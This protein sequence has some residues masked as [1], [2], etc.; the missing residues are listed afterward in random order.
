[1]S[2]SW[3]LLKGWSLRPVLCRCWGPQNSFALSQPLCLLDEQSGLDF[4]CHGRAVWFPEWFQH[5]RCSRGNAADNPSF[6]CRSDESPPVCDM[7]R[8]ADDKLHLAINARARIPPELC[9]RVSTWT[10]T[11]LGWPGFTNSVASTRKIRT[12]IPAASVPA[13]DIHRRHRHYTVNSR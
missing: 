3:G 11:T 5:E 2:Q 13:V 12:I 6:L 10:A 1:M 7:H 4:G 9:W 8:I